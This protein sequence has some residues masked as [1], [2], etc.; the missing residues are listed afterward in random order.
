MKI[1]FIV[2][3]PFD[4]RGLRNRAAQVEPGKR[5]DV[6]VAFVAVKNG[7]SWGDTAQDALLMDFFVYEEGVASEDEGFD[8]VCIDSVSDSGLNAL[9]SRLRIPVVGPGQ[10]CVHLALLLGRTFSILTMWE[11][12]N[13]LYR[14]VLMEQGA[15][16]R[17][18]SIRHPGLIP[19]ARNLLE[20]K[21]DETFAALAECA[22]NCIEHDGADVLILGSTT[23]HQAHAYLA[24][25]LP[26]PVINPGLVALKVAVLLVELGLSQS[27]TAY[28]PPMELRDAVFRIAASSVVDEG[29][30]GPVTA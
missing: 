7:G 27:K 15:L 16:E 2:P 25:R 9:R 11:K 24:T 1:K 22:T 14:K 28:P 23:M 21:A 13:H 12:W 17:C 3:F 20:G 8:A 10:T 30:G 26:V 4:E 18:V 5:D 19:D 6:E 29:R